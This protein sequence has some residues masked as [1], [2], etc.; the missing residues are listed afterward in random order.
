[1]RLRTRQVGFTLIE[2]LVVIAVIALLMGILMP[3]LNMAK[4][5]GQGV[6]CLSNLKQIGLALHMY[7]DDYDRKVLRA[8]ATKNL[9]PG[10]DPVYWPTAYMGYIGGSKTDDVSYYYEVDVYDCPSYPE[11]EQTIDYIV[12]SFNFQ[13]PG[14]ECWEPTPL[15]SFPRPGSTIYMAD[16]AYHQ[17]SPPNQIVREEDVSNPTEFR[18][19]L[20]WLDAY[21]AA[22]LPSEPDSTRRVARER[23]GKN[24]NCLFVDSHADKM[25]SM[26]MTTYD[27]GLPRT[28]GMP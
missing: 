6:R 11:K 4:K 18:H 23:H 13:N 5:Q 25:N 20:W 28:E 19:K 16:Y 24:T 17:V 22:H 10:Q 26:D 15:E 3:A 21:N 8:E 9:K 27:W 14:G 7:A 12:S 2:L 1:M